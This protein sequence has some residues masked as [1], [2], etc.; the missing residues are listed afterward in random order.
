MVKTRWLR[1]RTYRIEP[2]TVVR[3]DL[4]G[5]EERLCQRATRSAERP[6]KEGVE[7]VTG[8]RGTSTTSRF[9]IC[10][11]ART[12]R[13]T[14]PA[15]RDRRHPLRLRSRR[16]HH[17]RPPRH[18]RA[19]HRRADRGRSAVPRRADDPARRRADPA[20][21]ARGSRALAGGRG[22]DRLSRD[23]AGLRSAERSTP[24]FKRIAID[25][26]DVERGLR[27][28][29]RDRRRRISHRA[30]GAA[31]HRAE[32]RHRRA[33]TTAGGITVYGSMQCPYYVHRA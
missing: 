29:R 12:I 10:C 18:S 28:R 1:R 22:P 33:E 32:R 9:P 4:G 11:Y 15:G 25:K 13:S 3:A 19:Q 6:R 27:A 7:K 5:V 23:D 26:G 2:S 21:R 17:R 14:I 16:L 20:A 24:I 8:A 31:L 30:S